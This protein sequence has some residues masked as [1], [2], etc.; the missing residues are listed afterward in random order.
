MVGETRWQIAV[1]PIG[2]YVKMLDER[3]G[4]VAEEELGRAFNRQ[5]VGK[6]MLIVLAGPVANLIAAVLLYWMVFLGG[7]DVEA[8]IVGSVVPSSVADKAGFRTGDVV[9]Q[10]GARHIDGWSDIML[11][12]IDEASSRSRADVLLRR[13]TGRA[14]HISLDMTNIDKAQ[15]DPLLPDHLGLFPT[16]IRIVF[17]APK[18]NTVAAK[19]GLQKDDELLKIDGREVTSAETFIA[20]IQTR[21]GVLTHLLVERDGRQVDVSLTPQTEHDDNG[22]PIGR[23]GIG[24]GP[25]LNEKELMALHRH[26]DL[27]PLA[28]MQRA[29]SETYD[30]SLFTLKMLWRLVVGH[31]SVKQLSG[32]VGIAKLAGKSAELGWKAFVSS[33]CLVSISLGVLNLLPIPVLDG[34]HL[35]YYSAELL[36]GRPLSERA[37]ELGL[38]LGVGLLVALMAV[39]LYNDVARN[40][41]GW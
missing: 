22:R 36:R 28:A 10:V 26:I 4:A 23:I 29:V 3:E 8:P 41:G 35:L 27:S 13:A 16:T 38:R 34:G 7:V 40:L 33:M 17:D 25:R 39:A 32:P 12:L 30:Q 5:T 18:P 20:E 15:V 14:E 19:A 37:M 21:S 24:V 31:V 9:E 1:L 11:A 6:R 2:G